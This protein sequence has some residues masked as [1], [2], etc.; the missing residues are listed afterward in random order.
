MAEANEQR[1][2][3][4]DRGYTHRW[5]QDRIGWIIG[6]M[7]LVVQIF[8][9]CYITS[10]VVEFKGMDDS[11]AVM[12][13]LRVL[14]SNYMVHSG[15]QSRMND[16]GQYQLL[17]QV[18]RDWANSRVDRREIWE[19]VWQYVST[20]ALLAQQGRY[21]EAYGLFKRRTLSLRSDVLVGRHLR[22]EPVLKSP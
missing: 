12:Q 6:L 14:R 2:M 10:A 7:Q 4:N 5:L 13:Y 20:T 9:G 8:T 17:G 21:A 15:V 19:Y 16:L 18:L 1:R 22:T 11:C 3:R